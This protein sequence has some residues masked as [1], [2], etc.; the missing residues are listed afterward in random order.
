[1]HAVIGVLSAPRRLR[2]ISSPPEYRD[3]GANPREC[4][5]REPRRITVFS[6]ILWPVFSLRKQHPPLLI[7]LPARPFP[8]GEQAV[9]PQERRVLVPFPPLISTRNGTTPECSAFF[10]IRSQRRSVPSST[11]VFSILTTVCAF[12]T[13]SA[14]PITPSLLL[15]SRST[16]TPFQGSPSRL[17]SESQYAI[18]YFFSRRPIR[19]FP[20]SPKPKTNIHTPRISPPAY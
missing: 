10:R 14:G 6:N 18:A 13:G 1:V 9:S 5:A 11:F 7:A 3:F 4:H 16:L 12:P 17:A 19:V 8:G 20:S 2:K 15:P